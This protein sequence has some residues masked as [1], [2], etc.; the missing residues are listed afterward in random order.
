MDDYPDLR[1]LMASRTQQLVQFPDPFSVR[2]YNN[3][4]PNSIVVGHEVNAH[5][6]FEFGSSASAA[7]APPNFST[8]ISNSSV[9]GNLNG[10][11]AASSVGSLYGLELMNQHAWNINGNDGSG[12]NSRWPRQETL[13]LLEI[14]SS[15]D[16]KFKE[17]NQKGPLWDEVSRIMSEDH[18]YHRSG[19]KCKEKFENLYKYYKKTK[20]GKAGRQDGKHYRFFR[21]LEAIYGDQ[22]TTNP[23][24]SASDQTHLTG[25]LNPTLLYNHTTATINQENQEVKLGAE[26]LSFSNNST[27]LETSSSENNGDDLSNSANDHSKNENQIRCSRRMKKTW[28]TQVE[29][30]VN[31]QMMKV[32]KAQE[33]WMEKMLKTIEG[34]EEERLAK[35]EEWRKREAERFNQQVHEFWA[36]ER[37]WVET[38]DASIMEAL[39]Q[40]RGIGTNSYN[41]KAKDE[42]MGLQLTDGGLLSSSSNYMNM[43]STSFYIPT[44]E[45]ENLW[46]RYGGKLSK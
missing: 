2:P 32:M 41:T 14:R 35:E 4:H 20:E 23:L 5:E 6:F 45:G 38:R 33:G 31:S 8:I 29:G 36:N 34:R 44:N 13:T 22:S 16:S 10:S 3:F 46:N 12:N 28:K 39:S 37:A 40:I 9:A 30:F 26:S 15:L 43:N 11:T 7:G 25:T 19:K 42:S 24:S 18:G 17:T 27:D 21:Q 1:Q